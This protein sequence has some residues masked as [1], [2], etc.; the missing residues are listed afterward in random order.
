MELH[1]L[2]RLLILDAL[3]A[4]GNLITVRIVRELREAMSFT[5]AEIADNKIVVAPGGSATWAETG[6]PKD[7]DI[8]PVALDIIT[9]GLHTALQKWDEAKTLTM[10]HLE[11]LDKFGVDL[12]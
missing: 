7:I 4:T 2:E 5:E 8:G 1:I 12:D 3:P 6:P 10:G 9:Q 11:L